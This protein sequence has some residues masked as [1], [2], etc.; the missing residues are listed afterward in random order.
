MPERMAGRIS[1]VLGKQF[2]RDWVCMDE[3]DLMTGK[4]VFFGFCTGDVTLPTKKRTP[5]S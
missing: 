5:N 1:A 2:R 3:S 4:I